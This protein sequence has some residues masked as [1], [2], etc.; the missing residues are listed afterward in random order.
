M[1]P[2][3]NILA[4]VRKVIENQYFVIRKVLCLISWYLFVSVYL[5]K[6]SAVYK[7][8]AIGTKPNLAEIGKAN[9]D[10]CGIRI[11]IRQD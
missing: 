10:Y 1:K 3:L 4:M 5:N 9:K 8:V 7:I 6:N 2:T 11:R